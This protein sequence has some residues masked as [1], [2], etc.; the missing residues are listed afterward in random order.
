MVKQ[1]VFVL[2][3]T[4]LGD[5]RTSTLDPTTGNVYVAQA[6][7][8]VAQVAIVRGKPWTNIVS[9]PLLTHTP[10]PL[11]TGQ[12]STQ[13]SRQPTQSPTG[14][15]L[16]KVHHQFVES[17][18]IFMILNPPLSCSFITSSSSVGLS[19]HHLCHNFTFMLLLL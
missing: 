8:N 9:H 16:I 3:M 4:G 18:G 15:P 2:T 12:P 19:Y 13:P 14:I 6:D 7:N 10:T 5:V 1:F 11:P 17:E